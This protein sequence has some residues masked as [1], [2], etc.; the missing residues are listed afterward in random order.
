MYRFDW[1][2]RN[3]TYRLERMLGIVEVDLG[4]L[5]LMG[6]QELGWYVQRSVQ[7]M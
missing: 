5:E 4:V 1:S 2:G 7:G 6:P 3:P